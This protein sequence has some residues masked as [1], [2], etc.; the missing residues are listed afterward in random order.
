MNSDICI[1]F[2]HVKQKNV[3]SSIFQND[4]FPTLDLEN[5]FT[6][7]VSRCTN[8]NNNLFCWQGHLTCLDVCDKTE[9]FFLPRN[10]TDER[11]FFSKKN[12]IN[13]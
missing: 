1:Y 6:I 4:C 10:H 2:I 11:L 9:R 5:T 13:A 3:D 8:K 7:F 12:W